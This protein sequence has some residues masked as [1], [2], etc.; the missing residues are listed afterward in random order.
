LFS[1]FGIAEAK[2]EIFASPRQR[3]EPAVSTSWTKIFGRPI[4]DADTQA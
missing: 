4:E 2:R 1:G 3:L